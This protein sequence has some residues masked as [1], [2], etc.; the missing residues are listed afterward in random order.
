MSRTSGASRLACASLR[1]SRRATSG[2]YVRPTSRPLLLLA[3]AWSDVQ[4]NAA[5][6]GVSPFT[7]KHNINQQDESGR[8]AAMVAAWRGERAIL[9][10]L[11]SKGCVLLLS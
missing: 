8:T 9:K 2:G 10:W 3:E 1:Q 5:V 6:K 4:V 11:I 7:R